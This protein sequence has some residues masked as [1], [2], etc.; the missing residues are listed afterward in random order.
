[1]LF[2][3]AMH[4][5]CSVLLFSLFVAVTSFLQKNFVQE[6]PLFGPYF[7]LWILIW[8]D[9]AK[10]TTTRVSDHSFLFLTKSHLNLSGCT[11]KEDENVN[12]PTDNA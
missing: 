1:M 8:A 10:T 3:I 6:V 11:G 5:V 2:I 12:S 7:P 4:F 9:I